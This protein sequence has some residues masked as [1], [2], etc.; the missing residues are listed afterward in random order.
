MDRCL[1]WLHILARCKHYKTNNLQKGVNQVVNSSA[2]DTVHS[3]PTHIF[4]HLSYNRIQEKNLLLV[5]ILDKLLTR[6]VDCDGAGGQNHSAPR[7]PRTAPNPTPPARFASNRQLGRA[8][9]RES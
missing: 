1:T 5:R 8:A 3:P 9:H 7:I 2:L 6:V 4:N